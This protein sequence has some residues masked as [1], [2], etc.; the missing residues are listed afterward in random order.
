[1]SPRQH[2]PPFVERRRVADDG[3]FFD[4]APVPMQLLGDDGTILRA[5]RAEL[6]L[7]GYSQ[8]KYVGRNIA[9][10]QVDKGRAAEF[11]ARV[12]HH[13]SVRNVK[14]Q[15]RHRDGTVRYVQISANA[16]YALGTFVHIRTVTRDISDLHASEMALAAFKVMV[17]AANDAIA[18]LSFAGRVTYWNPAAERLYGHRAASIVGKPFG[19]VL[20]AD[21]RHALADM[22]ARVAAGEQMD[23][24]EAVHV[25]RD[26][27][28][29]EVSVS[30]FAI[31]DANDNPTRA[32]MI[33][34]DISEQKQ[35][36]EQLRHRLLHDPLT[37]VPNRVF[38]NER[39]A[40]SLD[41][42]RRERGYQFAVLFLD[43]DDFKLVND[44]LGHLAGD[45][46]LVQMA[47]RLGSCVRPSDLVARLGGDEF[48]ILLDDIASPGEL[49]QATR[50][51]QRCLAAPYAIAGQK[52]VATASI[53]IAK[54]STK[55]ARAEDLVRD[56]DIA[57]YHAKAK[58]HAHAAAFVPAMRRWA[59]DRFGMTADLR[60]AIE[61]GEFRLAYQPICEL[62]TARVRGFEALV[63]W[64][65]PTRGEIQPAEFIP[66]AEETGLIVPIGAWVLNE[67]CRQAREWQAMRPDRDPVRIS[68][69]LSGRQLGRPDIV[70]HVRQALRTT[71]LNPAAL[72]LEI[73]ETFLL[74][75]GEASN[76]RLA[77]LRALNVELHVDD[78]GT[79][80]SWLSYLPRF[81]LQALKVDR[82]FVNRMGSRRTDLEIVRSIVQLADK[83]DLRVIAEGIE[84]AAQRRRLVALGCEYGQGFLFSPPVSATATKEMLKA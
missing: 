42:M 64:Q 36:E 10:F 71:S 79:G 4:L 46:L 2:G 26:G 80:Y 35:A 53:G 38:F 39:V 32:G 54:A 67:A 24:Q 31:A 8:D 16:V 70:D 34:R 81:P 30:L 44:N 69:N 9:E 56:A 7:L 84:T 72:D 13:K 47:A 65:H 76:A 77:E 60:A 23:A 43:C 49:D 83:L 28:P 61:R 18:G 52:V 22:L 14:A 62:R 58:G 63:R 68:V 5:N 48:T 3:E 74:E 12:H 29:L 20:K 41:R 55:Y 50:R 73:T 57:M 59:N 17:D 1:M 40:Q 27:T 33:V 19:I 25:R 51:L 75:G 11:L 66:L 21:Q 82:S 45:S 37:N 78:F 15:L 6:D